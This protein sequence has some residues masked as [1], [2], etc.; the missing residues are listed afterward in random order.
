MVGLDSDGS[1]L[2]GGSLRA[3]L[4]GP[5]LPCLFCYGI[6]RPDVISAEIMNPSERHRRQGEGYTANIN[7]VTPS[8]VSFTTTAAGVAVSLF[9]DFLVGY[10][11]VEWTEPAAASAD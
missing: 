11:T 8:V 10:T 5:E 7:S 2:T 9:L 6:A 1:R 3:T 4:I